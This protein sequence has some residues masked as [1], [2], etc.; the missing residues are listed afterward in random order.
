[1]LSAKCRIDDSVWLPYQFFVPVATWQ[2][3]PTSSRR[4]IEADVNDG[5]EKTRTSSE[6]RGTQKLF[7]WSG[8]IETWGLVPW[9]SQ[10]TQATRATWQT[11]RNE[12]GPLEGFE[13]FGRMLA[14]TPAHSVPERWTE[15]NNAR[16]QRRQCA[17][18]V[19]HL[20]RACEDAHH[21]EHVV[22]CADCYGKIVD[23]MLTRYRNGE[24]REWFAGRTAFLQELEAMFHEVKQQRRRLEQVE[25]RISSEKEAWYRW[26]L[27][28]HPAFLAV[29]E[30]GA[31]Q[32]K[33]R[34]L[35]DDLDQTRG[36]LVKSMWEGMGQPDG[37]SHRVDDF[38]EK[39]AATGGDEAKLRD[40]Y[41]AEFLLN[42]AAGDVQDHAQP[43]LDEYQNNRT[44]TMEDIVDSIVK[45]DQLNRTSQWQ[46]DA[47]V[48][49]LDELRRAKTAFEQNKSR[50]R[51]SRPREELYDLPP[52][53]VCQG[54]VDVK[55][56]FSCSVCQIL[57]QMRNERQ[58][59]VYCSED[60]YY[61]G[62]VSATLVRGRYRRHELT[63]GNF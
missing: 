3:T 30:K 12:A 4:A 38:T 40:I 60:C 63:R 18:D 57:C 62:H 9:F 50:D 15:L 35:L 1:M 46:R 36:G 52:C 55:D 39:V 21:K 16:R 51:G 28:E 47:H 61:R 45:E 49:R 14:S 13:T 37:W 42:L 6:G 32:T 29:A 2:D 56:I 17:E 20:K 7:C 59:T 8:T 23:R 19:A 44:T 5:A 31:H 24:G 53:L 54:P 58:M 11:Q 34:S 27:R 26:M 25:A 22:Q 48:K 41:K 43:F 33:L 10:F